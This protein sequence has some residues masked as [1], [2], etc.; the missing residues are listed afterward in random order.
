MEFDDGAAV[1]RDNGFVT[2]PAPTRHRE[3][4]AKL[5]I[6][7][8]NLS[9]TRIWLNDQ[10]ISGFTSSVSLVWDAKEF[11]KATITII[12]GEL[13][14]GAQTLINLLAMSQDPAL[15]ENAIRTL[16]RAKAELPDGVSE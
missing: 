4:G 7:Q 8:S 13:E 11:T 5:R 16:K 15:L 3:T 12:V 2:M 1:V 10:D 14:C 6:E 9:T